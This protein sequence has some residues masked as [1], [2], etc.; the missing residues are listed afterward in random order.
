MDE[1]KLMPFEVAR[2]NRERNELRKEQQKQM[3]LNRVSKKQS[4]WNQTI[5]AGADHYMTDA[6][7]QVRQ[8]NHI[9]HDEK[10]LRMNGNWFQN[11]PLDLRNN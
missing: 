6:L 9:T 5:S 11:T 8:N 4:D 2:R 7:K 10:I 3:D 1:I